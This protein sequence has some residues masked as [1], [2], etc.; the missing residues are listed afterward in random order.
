MKLAFITNDY[1]SSKQ[2]HTFLKKELAKK[3]EFD[4]KNP[5][6]VVCIGGDGTFLSAVEKYNDQLD[7]V[8]FLPLHG[9]TLG[10]YADFPVDQIEKAAKAM[11][12]KKPHYFECSLIKAK[13]G[14]QNLYALNE[15][16]MESIGTTAIIDVCINDK[17]LES[18]RGDGLIVSTQSG[19]TA[20]N[21]SVGGAIIWP[22]LEVM[23]LSEIAGINNNVYAS[24]SN[25][26]VMS[27]EDK[28]T[29]TPKSEKL[30][31]WADRQSLEV[32]KGQNVT[33]TKADKK[34]RIA[35]FKDTDFI[36]RLQKAFIKHV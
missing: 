8:T 21:R 18:F 35:H 19:S 16:R 5:D 11:L 7:K 9:G 20:Y 29:L 15:V 25:S 33:I 34:V 6:I 12:T 31:L 27:I 32:K 13:V 1:K 23:Q 17:H 28:I 2:A 22:S 24:L 3:Y 36:S 10:F 4:S 30:V 26:V 14:K